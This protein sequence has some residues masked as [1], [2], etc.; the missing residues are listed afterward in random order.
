MIN[1]SVQYVNAVFVI[2]Q[3]LLLSY[4][5]LKKVW[6][7]LKEYIIWRPHFGGF[8]AGKPLRARLSDP[9]AIHFRHAAGTLST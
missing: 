4:H 3:I 1:I 9:A 6:I 7:L 8:E 5:K 2:F